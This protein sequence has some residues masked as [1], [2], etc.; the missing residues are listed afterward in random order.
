MSVYANF[1]IV[2]PRKSSE[3]T[4]IF[5]CYLL[6]TVLLVCHFLALAQQ[7]L[8]EHQLILSRCIVKASI[9]MDIEQKDW[10]DAK[11]VGKEII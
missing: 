7:F 4:K 3:N 9:P 10:L 1:L 2:N 8:L 11:P 6:E 5:L